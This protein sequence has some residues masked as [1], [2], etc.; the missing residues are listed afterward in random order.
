[1]YSR[2]PAKGHVAYPACSL[3]GIATMNRE[4]AENN[5]VSFSSY[6]KRAVGKTGAGGLRVKARS[7]LT[8][9]QKDAFFTELSGYVDAVLGNRF[10]KIQKE[11]ASHPS[12]ARHRPVRCFR[13]VRG[14]KQ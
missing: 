12:A 7:V 8:Q 6:A 9:G 2:R 4:K 10:S 3:V 14:R 11:S 13:L 5:V 1:M